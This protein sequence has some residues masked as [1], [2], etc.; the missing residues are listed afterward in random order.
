MRKYIKS[1]F[2]REYLSDKV[3]ELY[4]KVSNMFD[5]SEVA[6]DIL[7]K[8]GANEDDSGPEGYLTG[9]SEEQMQDMI[10]DFTEVINSISNRFVSRVEF[11]DPVEIE[12]LYEAV[13]GYLNDHVHSKDDRYYLT[14][15]LSKLKR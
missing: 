5:T 8:H 10:D 6:D 4:F 7:M 1:S 3:D 13:Y 2:D 15:I 9:V 11:T 12:T 14:S